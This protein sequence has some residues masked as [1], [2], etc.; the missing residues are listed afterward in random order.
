MT[1]GDNFLC[2]Q[3]AGVGGNMEFGLNQRIVVEGKKGGTWNA[4][5]GKKTVILTVS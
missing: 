1:R 2:K 5:Q 3:Q 4:A